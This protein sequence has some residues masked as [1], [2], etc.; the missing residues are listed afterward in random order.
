MNKWIVYFFFTAGLF[1]VSYILLSFPVA[2]Y[3]ATS[4]SL[5][6]Q[7]FAVVMPKMIGVTALLALVP[8]A[9]GV[10]RIWKKG[11]EYD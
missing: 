5:S 11:I 7:N 8:S 9:F 4:G 1:C 3:Y 10:Y 2:I 6:M